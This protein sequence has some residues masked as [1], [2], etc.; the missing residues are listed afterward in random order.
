MV[1]VTL[2]PLSVMRGVF[3]DTCN[4]R[5]LRKLHNRP[6]STQLLNPAIDYYLV[7][8]LITS[9]R[10]ELGKDIVHVKLDRAFADH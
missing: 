3:A 4:D 5:P 1:E 9:S 7:K 2:H 6:R 10:F 8:R